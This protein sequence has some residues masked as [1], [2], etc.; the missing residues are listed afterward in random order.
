MADLKSVRAE[1]WY[2]AGLEALK[3]QGLEGLK[4]RLLSDRL[5]VT[6]GSFY[7]HFENVQ[8][9]HQKL[10]DHWISW[11][12]TKTAAEAKHASSPLQRLEQLIED[13]ELLQYDDPIRLWARSNGL[14]ARAIARAD[15]MRVRRVSQILMDI[16][17]DADVAMKRAHVILWTAVHSYAAPMRWRYEVLRDLVDM[18]AAST[19]AAGNALYR[20]AE[21]NWSGQ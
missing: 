19:P 6:T 14:A 7:W 13:K 9:F 10:L 12:T 17:F 15:K 11:D 5:G 1:D 18:V 4:L 20:G 3:E 16:G 21:Q 8:D 2:F